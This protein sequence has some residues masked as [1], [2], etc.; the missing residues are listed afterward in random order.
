MPKLSEPN[1]SPTRPKEYQYSALLP[2]TFIG[3]LCFLSR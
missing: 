2:I 3:F 1:K